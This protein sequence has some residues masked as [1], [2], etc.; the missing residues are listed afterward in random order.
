MN[1]EYVAFYQS[2][3]VFREDS[4]IRYYGKIKEIKRYKRSECKEIPCEK[5]SEE[6]KYLRIDFEWIKEIPKIEPI[7][8]GHK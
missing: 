2:Q 8:Y 5:G 6:E 3:K 1:I 4:G 7:Q